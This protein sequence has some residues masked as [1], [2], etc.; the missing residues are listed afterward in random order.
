MHSMEIAQSIVKR[1]VISIVTAGSD[2]IK[3]VEG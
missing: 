1:N 2:V 3:T